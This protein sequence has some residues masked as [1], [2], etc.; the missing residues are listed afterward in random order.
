MNTLLFCASISQTEL[1]ECMGKLL[2]ERVAE[3]RAR[4]L[5]RELL[6]GHLCNGQC[7]IACLRE[8]YIGANSGYGCFISVRQR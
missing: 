7:R 1:C 2:E 4:C 5:E 6:V 8:G 3:G